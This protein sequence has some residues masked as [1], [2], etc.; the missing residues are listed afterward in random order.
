[1]DDLLTTEE[2]A[3]LAKK[4]KDGSASN[5]ETITYLKVLNGLSKEFLSVVK[6]MPTDLGILSTK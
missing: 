5:E 3:L 1:M 6:S 4:V 2:L